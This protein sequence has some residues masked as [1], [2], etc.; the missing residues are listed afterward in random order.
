MSE[1]LDLDALADVLADPDAPHR[2]VAEC[3]TC[4]ARLAELSAA[5]PAVTAALTAV[6]VPAEPADLGARL[7]TALAAE[8]APAPTN[9]L[10]LVRTRARWMPALAGI[11]A[12]AALV[13]GAVVL[14][15]G[16]GGDDQATTAT[17]GAGSYQ[18]NETG[19]NYTA[20]GT[21]LQAALPGL[22]AGTPA[23]RAAADSAATPG[24]YGTQAPEVMTSKQTGGATTAL[25]AAD[26]LAALRTTDGL[27]RCLSSLTDPSDEGVPLALDYAS[28]EG[29]PALVVVLPSSVA[30]KVD[31][32]VVPAGCAT[33][34][35]EVLFFTR[36]TRP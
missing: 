8:R 10:P 21:S 36:L 19:T 2:H 4:R 18:V 20:K 16:G 28:F 34:N 6:P 7:T 35:G 11:A 12:A 24:P 1:H 33:A 13:V 14:L 25:G 17:K 29:K 27:A 9:V 32:F 22:L 23:Q 31:V 30:N 3:A 5:L 26:P 15:P